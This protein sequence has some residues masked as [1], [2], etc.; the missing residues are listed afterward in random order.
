MSEI[1]IE[2]TVEKW[3]CY[4]QKLAEKLFAVG[5]DQQD[6]G[7]ALPKRLKAAFT[8]SAKSS[9]KNRSIL[10]SGVPPPPETPGGLREMLAYVDAVLDEL[11]KLEVEPM[12]V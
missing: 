8:A 11:G 3:A 2:R 7:N 5:S 9:I 1:E 4:R 12:K 6:C 10:I